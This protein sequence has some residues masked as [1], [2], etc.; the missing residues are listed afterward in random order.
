[1]DKERL[2]RGG[3]S[4]GILE[5]KLS[6]ETKLQQGG[7]ECAHEGMHRSFSFGGDQATPDSP[8]V[9]SCIDPGRLI[10]VR[11][12][13]RRLAGRQSANMGNALPISMVNTQDLLG[14]LLCQAKYLL[15]GVIQ[16]MRAW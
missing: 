8:L 16:G 4:L 12:S 14:R 15:T 3:E 1:M 10:G 6:E 13:E 7:T 9:T 11:V 5:S 2:F